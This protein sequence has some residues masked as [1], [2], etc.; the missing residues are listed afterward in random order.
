VADST[1]PRHAPTLIEF[2]EEAAMDYRVERLRTPAECE[3]FVKNALAGQRPDLALE[4][5]RK[6]VTMQAATHETTSPVEAEAFAALY[7]YEALLTRKNGKKTRASKTWAIVRTHGIIEAIQKAVRR[8]PDATA[9]VALREL[10]LDDLS[11]EALV[12]RHEAAFD[13][14]T[15]QLSKARLA[16]AA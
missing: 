9:F 3:I 1:T 14:A 10:G 15:V 13:A 11:F 5:R 12:V 2:Q 6:A 8:P 7:A 16:E 4:A